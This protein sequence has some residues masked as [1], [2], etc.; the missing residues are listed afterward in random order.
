MSSASSCIRLS[1]R[2]ILA[3][4]SISF[5]VTAMVA[6]GVAISWAAPAESVT[7]DAR[8]SF[9]ARRLCMSRISRSLLRASAESFPTKKLMSKAVVAK[10]IH[11]PRRCKEMS[12]D[13][14]WSWNTETSREIQKSN[15][16]ERVERTPSVHVHNFLST[17][18]ENV[19]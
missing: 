18:A 2:R 7:R 6:S 17:T 15:P 12:A 4:C 19:I 5:A 8:R 16:N 13:S 3:S 10:A 9:L 11:I 14:P 1:A